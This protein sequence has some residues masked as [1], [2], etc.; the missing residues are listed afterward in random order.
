MVRLHLGCGKKYIPGFIHIDCIE[1]EHIDHVC[2]IDSLPIEN[3]SVDLIYCCHVLEHFKIKDIE[4]V[5]KEW[6]RI[7]K[8]NGICRISVPDFEALNDVYNKYH[9]LKLIIGPIFGKQNYLYNIHNTIFDI[10]TIKEYLSKVGFKSID[11]YDW[12]KTEHFNID[13]YSQAYIPHMD[14]KNGI[15]I[16]LNIEAIK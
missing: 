3:N 4:R 13:D 7:L 6:Y 12:R 5:L 9:D 2:S 8:P 1:Y 10:K 11:R 14:K 15:L 16:S